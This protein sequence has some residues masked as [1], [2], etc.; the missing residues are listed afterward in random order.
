[1]RDPAQRLFPDCLDLGVVAASRAKGLTDVWL[2]RNNVSA[3]AGKNVPRDI[4]RRD[5]A[6]H[7]LGS[8]DRAR[9]RCDTA[10]VPPTVATNAMVTVF[11]DRV[12]PG[13]G[14]GRLFNHIVVMSC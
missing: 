11:D 13:F 2:L 3:D 1:M 9:D 10:R 8:E 7:D 6:L 14:F 5:V 12:C 4:L